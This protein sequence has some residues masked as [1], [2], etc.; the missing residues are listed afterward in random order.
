MAAAQGLEEG[1]DWRGELMA[2][3]LKMVP[4]PGDPDFLGGVGGGS[5]V[6]LCGGCR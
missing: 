2:S 3:T 5:L 1:A 6:A 4:M